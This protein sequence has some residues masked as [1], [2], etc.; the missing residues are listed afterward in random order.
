MV[1][2]QAKRQVVMYLEGTHGLSQRRACGMVSLHR[3]VGRYVFKKK[4]SD[5][6]MK[7]RLLAHAYTRP[8]F[9]YRRLGMLLRHQEKVKI[10]D[11]RIYRLYKELGLSVKRRKGRKKAL[12]ARRPMLTPS[13]P[14][15]RW[16]LDF[17]HDALA[18]GRKLRILTII[19]DFSREA[20]CCH[21]AP[22][23]NGRQVASILK[24][25]FQQKGKPTMIVSD[26]GTEF[27]SQAVLTFAHQED[28]LWHY[29]APGKPT[30]N[31]F[32]ESFNG[33]L[34]DECLNQHWFTNLSHAQHILE[35]WRQD[36]NH[37]RPHTA[38][39]GQTPNQINLI[40]KYNSPTYSHH[41][42]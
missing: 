20:L 4:I 19:D 42:L 23:I 13:K 34:R 14:V 9:G 11:K 7:E 32:I 31:A 36:Y 28:I 15:Q 33:K 27:T 38:L 8:R 3:S 41:N 35:E 1:S 29:I 2:P 5:E 22:S 12:G 6:V 17:V 21:V 37:V 26:N 39:K 24:S 25:L 40:A 18:D 30:Q 16:S 10:N